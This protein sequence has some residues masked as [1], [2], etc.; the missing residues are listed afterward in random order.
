MSFCIKTKKKENTD[1]L[2]EIYSELG[3]TPV[4]CKHSGVDFVFFFSK[5]SIEKW[6]QMESIDTLIYK[7]HPKTYEYTYIEDVDIYDKCGSKC[8]YTID[9]YVVLSLE[10][11]GKWYIN[12]V[13]CAQV[14][15]YRVLFEKEYVKMFCVPKGHLVQNSSGFHPIVIKENKESSINQ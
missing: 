1:F 6:F 15:N 12:V 4:V 14:E 10:S 2:L 3:I 9:G 7:D 5:P 8:S 11:D 13:D